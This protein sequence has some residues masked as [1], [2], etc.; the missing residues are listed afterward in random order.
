VRERVNVAALLGQCGK[1]YQVM[2]CA[3]AAGVRLSEWERG[4]ERPRAREDGADDH[5][6]DKQARS[7]C[8]EKRVGTVSEWRS[9]GERR[10]EII[11]AD[12]E[13]FRERL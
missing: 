5:I 10:R 3:P 7:L 11:S 9:P 1:L 6:S 12:F 2:I 8:G 4:S 13:M